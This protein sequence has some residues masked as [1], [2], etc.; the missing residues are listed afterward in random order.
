VVASMA[1]TAAAAPPTIKTRG[2]IIR[3]ITPINPAFQ[4][5]VDMNLRVRDVL[6]RAGPS[7]RVPNNSD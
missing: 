6:Q 4:R 7:H 1:G 3:K 2:T 5:F